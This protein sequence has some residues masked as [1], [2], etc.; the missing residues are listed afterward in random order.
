M[1]EYKIEETF[2]VQGDKFKC[3]EDI[4]AKRC[5]KCAL[6]SAKYDNECDEFACTRSDR[7]DGKLTI[8]VKL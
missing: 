8:A 2:E 6:S 3:V 4:N 1:K 7:K 5:T